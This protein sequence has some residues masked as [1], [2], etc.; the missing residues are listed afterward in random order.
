MAVADVTHRSALN[1]VLLDSNVL[2]L[3]VVGLTNR[4]WIETFKRTRSRYRIGDFDALV[5]F[6]NRFKRCVT[7]PHILAEVSALLGQLPGSQVDR[8]RQTL[9]DVARPYDERFIPVASLQSSGI[10]IRLGVTDAAI[11]LVA[12]GGI[13][14]LT[15]DAPLYI[16]LLARGID[17]QNFTHLRASDRE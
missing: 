7:T 15:D 2:L 6:V 10:A 9:L 8:A 12:T 14:I 5:V 11:A 13:T 1:D 4:A 3:L 16:E 17:S